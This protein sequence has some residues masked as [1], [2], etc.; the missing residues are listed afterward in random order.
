MSGADGMKLLEFS[1]ATVC[2]CRLQSPYLTGTRTR[3]SFSDPCAPYMT[4]K[5]LKILVN[6]R[7]NLRIWAS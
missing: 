1:D 7:R 5:L 3:V 6:C 2:A 4:W